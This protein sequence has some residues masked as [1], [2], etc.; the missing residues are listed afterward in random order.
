MCVVDH[1]GVLSPHLEQASEQRTGQSLPN[2]QVIHLARHGLT[3][4]GIRSALPINVVGHLKRS[5][6]QVHLR[7]WSDQHFHHVESI[8][9]LRVIQ[10]SEP[11]LRAVDDTV[12]LGSRHSRVRRTECVGGPR[13]YF[14]KNQGLGASIAA[15]QVNFATPSRSKIPVENAK[16][17]PSKIIG[18]HFFAFSAKG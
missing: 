11:F 12:L 1:Q 13:F 18:G 5:P 15:N 3:Y 6:D 8:W 7:G 17:I 9:H 14:H 10:Q 2:D 16:P 4:A